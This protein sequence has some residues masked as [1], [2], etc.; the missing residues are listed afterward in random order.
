M[1]IVISGYHGTQ[2][3]VQLDATFLVLPTRKV[4]RNLFGAT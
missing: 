1:S 2:Y 3:N 4:A